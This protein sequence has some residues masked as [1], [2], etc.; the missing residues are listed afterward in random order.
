[1]KTNGTHLKAIAL[2]Q[3]E[4]WDSSEDLVAKYRNSLQQIHLSFAEGEK[5]S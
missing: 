5:M 2:R 1:M 3:Q 4:A